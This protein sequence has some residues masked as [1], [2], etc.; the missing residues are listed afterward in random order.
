[1][2][3]YFDY[4]QSDEARS[5]E[6]QDPALFEPATMRRENSTRDRLPMPCD[7]KWAVPPPRGKKH[8]AEDARGPRAQPARA[9]EARAVFQRG[10]GSGR[11]A[12]WSDPVYVEAKRQAAK[13][14]FEREWA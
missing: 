11:E 3:G 5:D 9:L 6:P 10:E 8:R 7:E 12:R 13:R 14:R 4:P 2:R 1:M